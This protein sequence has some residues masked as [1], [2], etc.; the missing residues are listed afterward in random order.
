MAAII[1]PRIIEHM[2]HWQL[3]LTG[4]VVTR[5]LLDHALSIELLDR[6]TLFLL[7]IG[8]NFVLGGE[9]GA[10]SLSSERPAELGPALALLHAT[11]RSAKAN[12]S[13]GLELDLSDGM[14]VLVNADPLYEAWEFVGP[15]Q[16][17][18]VCAP[19]GELSVW[20]ATGH[21]L[22]SDAIH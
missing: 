6:E 4:L 15:S 13:G 8:N 14:S 11:V 3:P 22:R 5:L 12:K 9:A 2:D 10:Q 1:S 18:V 7:R 16:M 19:G 20:H 21:G 17:R